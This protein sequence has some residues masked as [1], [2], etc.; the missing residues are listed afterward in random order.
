MFKLLFKNMKA[1]HWVAVVFIFLLTL[2][3]VYFMMTIVAYIGSLTAAVGNVQNDGTTA[4]WLNGLG[5]IVCAVAMVV[6]DIIIKF[7]ASA[8]ASG[9]V[10][11]LRQKLYERVNEFAIADFASFSTESLITRTTN[12]MQNVHL[13]WLTFLKTAFVAPVTMV[14]SIILLATQANGKLTIVTAIWVFLLVGAVAVLLLMVTPKFRIVQKLTDALNVSSRENLTG[15]RVVRAFNAETYQEG[16]FENVN[17]PYTK[18]QIFVG[19]VLAF[20][21]PFVMM[22]MMGLSLSILW[23]SAYII[24]GLSLEQA[25]YLAKSLC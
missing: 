25:R 8:T 23:V 16:K 14:W 10:T 1:K 7:I 24:N 9:T 17:A 13:A 22:V 6:V 18:V 12:D 5:M 11:F 2:A 21:T 3:E 15:V 20:F 19:R 4:V